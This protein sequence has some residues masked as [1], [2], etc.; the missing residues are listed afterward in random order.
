MKTI[1]RSQTNLVLSLLLLFS[2]I[3]SGCSNVSMA[4]SEAQRISGLYSEAPGGADDFIIV[5]CKLPGQIRQLGR[6]LV[7][8]S[9][10]TS[11]KT[12]AKDCA[13]RGGEFA[14]PG[15]TDYHK[16][17]LIWQPDA[18]QGDKEAQYYVGEIYQRGLGGTPQYS[19]AV[20]WYRK[21]AEQGYA[22][23]QMNLAYLY[24]KGLGVEKDPQQ[25]LRWYRKA[26]GLGDS[27]TLDTNILDIK[28]RQE[29]HE[30][31]EEVKRRSEDTKILQQKLEQIQKNMEDTRRKLKERSEDVEN[32]IQRQEVAGLKKKVTDDEQTIKKLR[33][34]LAQNEEKLSNLPAP[35]I[36]IFDP[37]VSRG[38]KF[39][40]GNQDSKKRLISGIVWAPAGLSGFTINQKP[41]V[42]NPDGKFRAWIPLEPSGDTSVF[43]VAVDQRG[44]STRVTHTLTSIVDSPVVDPSKQAMEQI[45]SI[46][47][48]RYHALVIGNINYQKL[49]KLRTAANDA[50]KIAEVL[51]NK[52]GFDTEL[53]IDATRDDIIRALDRF[54]E[55]LTEKDN[56][57]IY[58]AGHGSLD[59]KNNR[60]YWQ[61]V[62]ADPDSTVNWISNY[63]V[64]DQLNIMKAKEVLIIADSC[65]SGALTRGVVSQ[66]KSA[67]SS[68]IQLQYIKELAKGRARMVLSSGELAPV[69]DA[70]GGG[71]SVFA[72]VLLNVL[73]SNDGVIEGNRLHEEMSARVVYESKSFG[74]TQVPQYASNIQ[75]GH[76]SGDFIFVPQSQLSIL[77]NKNMFAG[78]MATFDQKN[79]TMPLSWRFFNNK[80]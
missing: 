17:L 46:D 39:E 10:G 51:R 79:N 76:V 52:Y 21:A 56:L 13:I 9:R 72:G 32:A 44:Q 15:Q 4:P 34:Q 8:L 80:P 28:E 1:K 22:K 33:D 29:L 23:A 65:Y 26:T 50:R 78:L 31:R 47:F 16:A 11:E 71:H 42:V 41:E 60:G 67:T 63:T 45:K 37:Q 66:L 35:R 14:V 74:L 59:S 53:L 75:A 77:Q 18:E 30:L 70:G 12:T 68:D 43:F 62:D 49:S 64:T 48:G 57:L 6:S 5:D 69:L 7:Y 40:S 54:R 38:I 2:I 73:E 58:Y 36:E 27:I 19:S 20:K 24:E 61:P 55:T 3:P 25:A